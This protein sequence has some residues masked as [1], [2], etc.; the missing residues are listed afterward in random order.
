VNLANL[1]KAMD[2]A[3]QKSKELKG[4]WEL[5]AQNHINTY[6]VLFYEFYNKYILLDQNIQKEIGGQFLHHCP[7]TVEP[8]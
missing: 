2:N 3:Q 5:Q 7:L 4:K 8:E 1:Q 6:Q